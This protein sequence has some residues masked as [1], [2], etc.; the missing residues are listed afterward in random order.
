MALLQQ[1]LLYA[2]SIAAAAPLCPRHCCS[3]YSSTHIVLLQQLLLYVHGIA[4][5]AIPLRSWHC[6]CSYSFTSMALLL[7]L[8]LYINGIAATATLLCPWHWCYVPGGRCPLARYGSA[9]QT[10]AFHPFLP[11]VNIYINIKNVYQMKAA[12]V[13][14]SSI[15]QHTRSVVRFRP[16]SPTFQIKICESNISNQTL[17]SG[18]FLF[19]IFGA[20]DAPWAP[21][22]TSIESTFRN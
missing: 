8:L 5:A 9:L 3:S 20:V 6:C 1:L 2:H 18:C 22:K 7:P 11:P 13:R 4:A 14:T 10:R 12:F 16:A 21:T 19:S 15:C 17:G